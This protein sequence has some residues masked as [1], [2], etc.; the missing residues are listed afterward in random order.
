MIP[1]DRL[2]SETDPVATCSEPARKFTT[3]LR[4]RQRPAQGYW[5]LTDDSTVPYRENGV[6]KAYQ[7][8][9]C[10]I[11]KVTHTRGELAVLDRTINRDYFYRPR[12]VQV[13]VTPYFTPGHVS[14]V[15]E[16]SFCDKVVI[17]SA[18]IKN[19]QNWAMRFDVCSNLTIKNVLLKDGST[20]GNQG[21]GIMLQGCDSYTIDSVL[22]DVDRH[23]VKNSFSTRGTIS[24][25]KTTGGKDHSGDCHGTNCEDIGF[26]ACEGNS[27]ASGNPSYA[28]DRNIRF[29]GCKAKMGFYI[30][31]LSMA[32]LVECEAPRLVMNPWYGAIPS[33]LVDA[34]RFVCPAG[35]QEWPGAPPTDPV[36]CN[37]PLT[38]SNSVVRQED[39]TP[40]RVCFRGKVAP[41]LG[42][43][44]D[45]VAASGRVFDISVA[46]IG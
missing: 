23:T 30:N 13:P 15:T 12:L 9:H 27:F 45:F 14:K 43:G 34:S 7:R 41:T 16:M 25:M 18:E 1:I 22:S 37:G 26:I 2:W 5:I 44:N 32:T 36:A 3:I 8:T 21:V 6:I 46:G 38:I 31:G 17:D 4:T 40:G 20:I 19:Y 35:Y 42:S 33:C 39:P 24:R 28:A 11:V 10:Q 29:T